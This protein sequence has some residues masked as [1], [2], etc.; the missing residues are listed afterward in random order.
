MQHEIVTIDKDLNFNEHVADI[1]RRVSN[2][3]QVMQRQKK[4]INTDTKTKLYKAYLLPHSYYCCVMW[5]HCSQ[6]NLRN[7]E[8]INEC[9]LRFVFNDNDS[10]YKQLLNG[11]GQPSLFNRRV[12]YILTLVYKSLNGLALEYITSMFSLKTHSI[13]LHTSGTNSLLIP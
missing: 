6:S 5:H 9:R 12:H 4:L 1:V 11:V 2:Q 10:D 13:N 7:L 8:K 3:I